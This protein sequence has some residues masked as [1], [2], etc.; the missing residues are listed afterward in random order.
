[1][2][3]CM[4][5]HI[6][7]ITAKKSSLFTINMEDKASSMDLNIQKRFKIKIRKKSLSHEGE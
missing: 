2:Y 7:M 4:C 6:Y 3:V 5:V 1:M